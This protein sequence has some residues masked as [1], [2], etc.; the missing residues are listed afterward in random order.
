MNVS[1]ESIADLII[2]KKNIG[3]FPHIGADGDCIGT[4][5]ALKL[6]LEK[7]NKTAYVIIDE[8]PV[9]RYSF[10]PGLEK[11]KVFKSQET[12]EFIDFIFPEKNKMLGILVDCSTPE[13]IGSSAKLLQFFDHLAVIDHHTN[14]NCQFDKC[15]IKPDASS[16]GELIFDLIKIIEKKT[17]TDLFDRD[18]AINI[19]S[20]I[21]FDTGGM[22]YSNTNY[23][24]FGYIE[25]LVRRFSPDIRDISYNLF[26][27]ST[28]S[29]I[30]I[31]SKAFSSIKFYCEGRVA[32][33]VLT[34]KMIEDCETSDDDMDGICT[35]VQNIEGVDVAFLLRE[36]NANEIRG[37]IRSSQNF[38]ASEFASSLGGGGHK[39]ASGFTL[40]DTSIYRVQEEIAKKS[41]NILMGC[42][43]K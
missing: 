3:I 10:M 13:R 33:S 1:L 31:Q 21:Y 8:N 40:T 34:K 23:K 24:V 19:I 22:R 15:F 16:T 9:D 28:V 26:E 32:I 35:A 41:T 12:E 20:A 25:E 38:D 7:L 6:A 17:S 42:G 14:Q 4:G 29:K 37:N 18:I 39:R 5:N 11:I 30:C 36:K 2:A 27:R 43:E